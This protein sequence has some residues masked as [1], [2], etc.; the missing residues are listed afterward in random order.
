MLSLMDGYFLLLSGC[1]STTGEAET[2]TETVSD[3]TLVIYSLTLK[4]LS[5]ETIP[6]FEKYGIRLI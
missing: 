3:N 6:A 2:N 5:E 4:T 1:S